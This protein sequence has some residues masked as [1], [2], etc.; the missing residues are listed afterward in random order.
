[1]LQMTRDCNVL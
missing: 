1:M